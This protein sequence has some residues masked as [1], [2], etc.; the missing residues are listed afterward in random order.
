MTLAAHAPSPRLRSVEQEV[1][2]RSWLQRRSSRCCSPAAPARGCG[3]C[4]AT[5]CPSSSCRW[6]ASAR[7]TRRRLRGCSDADLF[8]PPIVMTAEI[9]ASS[10]AAQAEEI[11]VDATIVLEPMRRDSGPAIAAGAALALRRD[12][13]AVVLALAADHVILD[14]E[15][16]PRRLRR[17]RARPPQAGCIVTFGITPTDAEDELR[18]HPPRR[19]ARARRRAMRSTPSSKS[20][21][22]RRP[23]RYVRRRL[24]VEFR[25]LP[26]PRRRAAGR[27]RALR[28]GRWRRRSRPRSQRAT[29]DLGFVRL[30]AEAFA[31]APQKSI[32]YAVMEKTDRA[33]V[34]EGRFRW[35]DIGSWDAVFD[36]APARRAPAMSCPARS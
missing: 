33:A 34:V 10:R 36:I 22:P 23:P 5:R 27:T 17:R 2:G 11:G 25:Q 8:A 16:V 26:V 14:V 32:D 24:S 1:Y 21:M 29:I 7:P 15:A 19:A 35:S 18:L 12:P 20:R 6:W 28:A 4:R 30:D 3:R 13:D 9:S 31:R